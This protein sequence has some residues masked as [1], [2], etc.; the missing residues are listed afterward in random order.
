MQA[1]QKV[2]DLLR[3]DK[4]ITEQDAETLKNYKYQ[5][6]EYTYID[7]LLN[8]YWFKWVEYLP[9]VYLNHLD[10]GSEYGHYMGT[11]LWSFPGTAIRHL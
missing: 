8:P 5:S 10:N 4:D 7:N 1:I 11:L 6:T 3:F 9:E 2:S